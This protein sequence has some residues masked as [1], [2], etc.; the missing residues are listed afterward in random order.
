[1]ICS[2]WRDADAIAMLK[3][4]QIRRGPVAS[5]QKCVWLGC[6]DMRGSVDV[7]MKKWGLLK[8]LVSNPR[9]RSPSNSN[10]VLLMFNVD[11]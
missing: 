8:R 7:R 11:D 4:Y 3:L 9:S 1:M 10:T 2:G 6:L 5:T